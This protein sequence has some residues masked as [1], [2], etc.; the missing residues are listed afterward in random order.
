MIDK[1][2][3]DGSTWYD[4]M[5]LFCMFYFWLVN[6]LV[7]WS[8]NSYKRKTCRVDA[9]HALLARTSYPQQITTTLW[10][11]T[12]ENNI[13]VLIIDSIEEFFFIKNQQ[14]REGKHTAHGIY[15]LS[16]QIYRLFHYSLLLF[17]IISLLVTDNHCNNSAINNKGLVNLPFI[18]QNSRVENLEL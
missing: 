8:A 9:V 7:P 15:V 17:F 16:Y 14:F 1:W 13:S 3:S 2:Y 18:Y 10:Q 4:I 5:H 11:Q 6:L 12:T